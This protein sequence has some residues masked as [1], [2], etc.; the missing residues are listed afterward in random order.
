M[1]HTKGL[2]KAF[3]RN[4]LNLF[5]APSAVY[6]DVSIGVSDRMC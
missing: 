5:R 2:P 6:S 3:L 4:S 1:Q